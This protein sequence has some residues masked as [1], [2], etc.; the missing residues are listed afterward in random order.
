MR[1][2]RAM[3]KDHAAE[4]M[5]EA[6]YWWAARDA[7]ERR[8]RI[9]G[10]LYELR[11]YHYEDMLQE[12][13]RGSGVTATDCDEMAKSVD[14]A[15]VKQAIEHKNMDT[16]AEAALGCEIAARIHWEEYEQREWKTL[17]GE[18]DG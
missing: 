14:A 8:A 1:S 10:V 16:C 15:A 9:W 7:A 5:H 12:Y 2:K 3:A 18:A 6:S 13:D 11:R 4:K 17:G